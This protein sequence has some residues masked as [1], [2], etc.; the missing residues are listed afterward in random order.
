MIGIMFG[1]IVDIL[2]FFCN[3]A[4]AQPDV[5]HCHTT[6]SARSQGRKL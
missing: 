1:E 5:I 2:L 4:R 3:A 6:K